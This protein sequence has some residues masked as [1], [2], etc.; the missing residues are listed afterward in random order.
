MAVH[1]ILLPDWL[2]GDEIRSIVW[3]D[4]AGTVS[5]T[6]RE[7]AELQR[8]FDAPKPVTIGDEGGTWD[9]RDP[10]HDPAEFLTALANGF[11]PVLREPHRSTLPAVFDGVEIPTADP[12]EIL[13]DED[14]R[15]LV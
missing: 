5:G 12:G 15:E 7:V 1:T 3:D 4:E 11:W 13:Y 8:V 2:R 9:L 14:G 6:H 10:A